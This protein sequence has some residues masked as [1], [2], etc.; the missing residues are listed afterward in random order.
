MRQ[1]HNDARAAALF[2]FDLQTAPVNFRKALR[3]GTLENTFT[4]VHCGSSK[5]FHGVQQL[6]DL[7]VDCLPSPLDRPP[8]DGVHPRCS[9]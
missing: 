9:K 1:P 3:K 8:V 6:L 5:H 2:A 4:P 7:V